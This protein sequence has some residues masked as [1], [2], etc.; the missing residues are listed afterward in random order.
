MAARLTYL[1]Q[2]PSWVILFLRY[3]DSRFTQRRLLRLRFTYYYTYYYRFIKEVKVYRRTFNLLHQRSDKTL[4]DFV[5]NG[6][7]IDG[8]NLTA[9]SYSARRV[10]VSTG[11]EVYRLLIFDCD[12]MESPINS[13]YNLQC[14]N[15][16]DTGGWLP[17]FLSWHPLLHMNIIPPQPSTPT[18]IHFL[19][20]QRP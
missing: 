20:G 12:P 15:C 9:G 8:V 6:A 3:R 10:L 18:I 14:S 1:G 2:W 5:V 17:F 13:I 11:D 16:W 19:V 7:A 4:L